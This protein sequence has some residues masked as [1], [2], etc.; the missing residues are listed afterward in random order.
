VWKSLLKIFDDKAL[1]AGRSGG[2]LNKI[3]L[4]N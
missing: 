4:K 2:L 3:G 1:I